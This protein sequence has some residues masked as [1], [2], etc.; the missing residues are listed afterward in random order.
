MNLLI[1]SSVCKTAC[2]LRVREWVKVMGFIF[3]AAII[4][5]VCHATRILL[6]PGRE[7]HKIIINY[8]NT[9]KI[10][11][12]GSMFTCRQVEKHIKS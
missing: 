7:T 4:I 12:N 3:T 2:L 6:S 1:G 5:R 11:N 9:S 10:K 8:E